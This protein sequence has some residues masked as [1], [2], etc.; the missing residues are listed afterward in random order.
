MEAVAVI[1]RTSTGSYTSACRCRDGYWHRGTAAGDPRRW[2][3]TPRAGSFTDGRTSERSDDRA[4]EML[5]RR[6]FLLLGAETFRGIGRSLLAGLRYGAST[7]PS[8]PSIIGSAGGRPPGGDAPSNAVSSS[9]WRAR[10]SS[11]AWR[12]SLVCRTVKHDDRLSGTH[13][14]V[15]NLHNIMYPTVDYSQLPDGVATYLNARSLD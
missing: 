3:V 14:A 10:F 12:H 6:R 13:K 7:T 9:R 4:Y 11:F 2:A 15:T 1:A 8:T 5:F